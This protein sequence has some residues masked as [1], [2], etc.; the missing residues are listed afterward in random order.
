VASGGFAF[1][2]GVGRLFVLV[3]NYAVLSALM[4]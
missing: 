4:V 3:A 1:L 2:C